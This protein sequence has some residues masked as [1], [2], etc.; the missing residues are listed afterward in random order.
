MKH[1]MISGA[2]AIVP[3]A[4]GAAVYGF[5]FGLLASQ[6]GF[7]WWG[8]G[9]MSVSVHAGASQIVAVE[10]FA[11]TGT[12]L[13]AVLAAAAL[14]LRYVGIVASLSQVLDGLPLG[15]KLIAI[16]ITGDENWALTMARRAKSPDV[17]AA[18]LMGS[19]LVMISVWTASTAGGALIGAVLPDLERFG[20]GFAFTAAFIAMARGLW[21]GRGRALPWAV[22]AAATMA[23][24]SFGAPRAY[25][26]VAGALSG[27]VVI[28]MMRRITQ[29]GNRLGKKGRAAS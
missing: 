1:G 17:G 7:P 11:T 26:I 18:F 2:V 14:N 19:G 10:Q 23:A 4:L 24:I 22:A 27:L 5:A 25:G 20:L 29:R 13:G 28:S 9:V 12:V 21:R 8:V 6:S 16:H 15:R 3:L